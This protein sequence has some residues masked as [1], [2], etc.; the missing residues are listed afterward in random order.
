MLIRLWGHSLTQFH[1]R[2]GQREHC[3][4]L[5][6]TPTATAT[7]NLRPSTRAGNLSPRP[8]AQLPTPPLPPHTARPPPPPHPPLRRTESDVKHAHREIMNHQRLLH[9]HVVQ[10]KEVFAVKPYL[11]LVME[12]VPNGDMFQVGAR[13]C[14]PRLLAAEIFCIAYQ[15]AAQHV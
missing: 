2:R 12:Y 9:P 8:Y 11:A 10:L 13:R 1:L 14:W 5:L 4:P 6:G 15:N 3:R 7:V